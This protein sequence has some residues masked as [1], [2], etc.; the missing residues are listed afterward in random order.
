MPNKP[1]KVI[2]KA[3]HMVHYYYPSSGQV[4]C[5]SFVRG[6]QLLQSQL[7]GKYTG[8]K[9]ASRCSEPIWNAH[10][11]STHHH[12]QVPVLH[13][14]EVRHTW[15]SHLAQG[16][17]IAANWQHWDSTWPP[18]L[19]VPISQM[20]PKYLPLAT[21]AY[22][23]FNTPNLA[24]LSPYELIFGKKL[25]LLL[26]LETTPNIKVSGIFK[27]YYNL[28]NKKVQYLHKLLQD[29]KS[30]RWAMINKDKSFFQYHSGDS[31]YISLLTSQ[32]CTASRKVMIK[33]VGPVVTY[34]I[35]DPHN[36][37]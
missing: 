17:Y 34:K 20:W 14:G 2:P 23:T 28:L 12:C 6:S 27:D 18:H 11:S 25:K 33:Y 10:Y 15:S 13:F 9:A 29:F 3:L 26:N 8:H 16:C 36:I 1:D 5:H 22:I 31:V 37:Y 30:K 24:N 19:D 21:F 4:L 32:L 7:P 35:I